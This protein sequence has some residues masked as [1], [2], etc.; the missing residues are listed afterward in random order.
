MIAWSDYVDGIAARVTG[1][2]SR[3]GALLDPVVDRLLILA[4]AVVCWHFELLPRWALAVLAVREV[5]HA[6]PRPLGAYHGLD[7]RI[8]WLG[9]DGRLAGMGGAVLRDGRARTTVGD[10]RCSTSGSCSV[11]GDRAVRAQRPARARAR[12]RGPANPQA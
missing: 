8:N 12:T 2:Y 9:R 3:L 1:Q 11:L 10:G 7:L 6:R 5:V 4:G